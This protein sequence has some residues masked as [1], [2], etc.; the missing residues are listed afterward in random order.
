MRPRLTP[1]LAKCRFGQ[2]GY[3]K[4]FSTVRTFTVLEEAPV[5]YRRSVLRCVAQHR[6]E[7]RCGALRGD[8]VLKT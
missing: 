7:P 5:A 4:S 2:S 3:A 1:N 8:A 6:A